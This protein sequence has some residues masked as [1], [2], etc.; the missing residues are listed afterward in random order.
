MNNNLFNVEMAETLK[1]GHILRDPS[2]SPASLGARPRRPSDFPL[3]TQLDMK[4]PDA[5][6][7]ST[8]VSLGRGQ[9][10]NGRDEVNGK[11]RKVTRI[12]QTIDYLWGN[13][14]LKLYTKTKVHSTRQLK[15]SK[16]KK[17]I[18]FWGKS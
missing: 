4:S 3:N 7:F 6:M 10:F 8:E 5:F 1:S 12:A 17:G 16:G 18:F 13:C 15:W 14:G 11:S 2:S 9:F